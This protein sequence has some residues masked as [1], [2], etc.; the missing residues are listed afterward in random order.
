MLDIP[1]EEGYIPFKIPSIDKPCST[2]FKVFG[3]L[4][5]GRSPVIC[6]HAGPGHVHQIQIDFAELWPRHGVPVIFYD[7][8]GF[9]QSTNLDEKAGNQSFWDMS[10]FV[11]ELEN[12][13]NHFRLH[14]DLGFSLL[15]VSLGAM[16][17]LDFAV[18]KPRGLRLLVLG[19]PSGSFEDFISGIN[20][21]RSELPPHA[22]EALNEACD[23]QDFQSEAWKEGA[24]MYFGRYL[25][26]ADPMP[27]RL[28]K[29]LQDTKPPN[30][31]L[32]AMLGPCH[33]GTRPGS[34][35][36]WNIISQLHQIDVDTLMWN[37]EFD[38]VTDTCVQPLFQK[39]PRVRWRTFSGAS[40]INTLEG[41]ELRNGCI[42]LV[43]DFLN[44]LE[45]TQTATS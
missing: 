26:R 33:M 38:Q 28:Q 29:T 42:N 39:I 43:G 8:I 36:T 23:K 3:D 5:C 45:P 1:F 14:D 19:S 40:H 4:S 20:A 7:M 30:T 11:S 37:G 21:R 34:L 17:A 16:L 6:L 27:E 9:G 10:L 2:Y 25:C 35:K 12:V 22:Q 32:G 18:R 44:Q 41:D 13:V 31:V 15:G 24:T